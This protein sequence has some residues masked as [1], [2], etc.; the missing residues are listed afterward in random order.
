[1]FVYLFCQQEKWNQCNAWHKSYE[2]EKHIW[3]HK[4]KEKKSIDDSKENNKS[5]ALQFIPRRQT[6][7]LNSPM[8]CRSSR[9]GSG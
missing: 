5:T 9:L 7:A 1:M 2:K 4:L 6:L 3:R 8:A